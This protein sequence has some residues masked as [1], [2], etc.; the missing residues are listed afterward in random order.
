VQSVFKVAWLARLRP[1]RPEEAS[2]RNWIETHGPLAASVDGLGSYVQNHVIEELPAGRG[3]D[4]EEIAVSGVST[5]VFGDRTAFDAAIGS[6]SWNALREDGRT[7]FDYDSLWG[8]SAVLEE[9][10]MADGPPA[11]GFKVV[12]I[13]SFKPGASKEERA[14]TRRHW[15]DIHGPIATEAPGLDRYVQNHAVASIGP[16]GVGDELDLAFGGFSEGWYA[17][18]AAYEECIASEPWRRLVADGQGLWGSLWVASV[19]EIVV[20]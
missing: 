16:G 18:R 11:G 2:R 3:P 1:D 13:V 14:E 9:Y 4:S 10:V 15:L 12:W 7:I 17:D 19:D 8:M 5:A 6:D 20:K